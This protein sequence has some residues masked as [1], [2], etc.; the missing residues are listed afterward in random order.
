MSGKKKTAKKT[1]IVTITIDGKDISVPHGTILLEAAR[2]NDIHIPTLCYH[3]DLSAFGGCRLCIV[4]VEGQRVPVASCTFPVTSPINVETTS[5]RIRRAR[6]HTIELLLSEHC[7]DCYSCKRNGNCELQKL[8]RDYGVDSYPFGHPT[9]KSYPIDDSGAI[10]RDMDKCIQC[11][12]CIRTCEELQGIGI[13]KFSGRGDNKT[14][15]TYLDKD[16]AEIACINCGQCITRCPTGALTERDDTPE[17]WAAIEDPSKHVV[18]QTAPSPR[19]AIGEEFG[20]PAGSAMTWE[21]NTALR[22]CGFDKVFDTNF[23][24][25]L[26]IIEEGT[27]LILRLYKNLVENDPSMPLPQFTSCCPGWVK[28]MEHEH[29]DMLDHFSTAKS[30]QQMFGAVIKTWYAKMNNIDPADIVSVSLMPC[31]AK[32]FEC[33]RPE[34]NDSGYQDVDYSITTREATRMIRQAGMHLPDIPK[35]EFDDPFGTATGSG[36]IFG[37]TGGV[38]E[39]ALRSVIEFVTGLKVEDI[40]DHADIIPVRGFEGCRYAEINIPEKLGQVPEL[41]QHLVPNW[42]WL[43]GV[44]LKV[45]VAHGIDNARKI[46]DDIAAG[47]TFSQ[48]HFIEV[49]ACPGGCLSGGGMPIPT[50]QA[51]RE[52]RAK[53]IYDEDTEYG[54]TGRARKSHENPVILKIYNE[55]LTEGP[56]GHK[57]HDLLH[58]EYT[59]RGKFMTGDNQK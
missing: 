51:I 31:T 55:F 29:P 40:F 45:G 33:N 9:E 39:A 3:E 54:K 24:A 13:F 30:P 10:V 58:V 2:E 47:G 43:K 27:E 17:I 25:D 41:I 36:I 35:S 42:D 5:D 1:E 6:R 22:R 28:F 38:M 44:T 26:T 15:S 46:L 57:S 18:I 19:V 50:D 20:L 53:A 49:M 12:R 32:K 48:C 16:M 11:G 14:V 4:E 21:L 7:G 56:C 8:A 23:S 37:A 52:A 34:M 59:Q